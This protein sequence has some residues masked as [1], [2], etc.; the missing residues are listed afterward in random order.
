MQNRR[1]ALYSVCSQHAPHDLADQAPAVA[2]VAL[3]H[4]VPLLHSEAA[5]RV[6]QFERPQKVRRRAEVLP[7][8]VDLVH[9]VLDADDSLLAQRLFDHFVVCD[10]YTPPC[11]FGVSALID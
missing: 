3:L 2:V 6:A 4:E 10:R 5:L 11:D 1:I 8:G 9:Q 7:R